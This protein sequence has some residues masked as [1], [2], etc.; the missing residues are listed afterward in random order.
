[1]FCVV[2]SCI[3]LIPLAFVQNGYFLVLF[4]FILMQHNLKKK[5]KQFF[6]SS[7]RPLFEGSVYKRAGQNKFIFLVLFSIL[8]PANSWR[9]FGSQM[10]GLAWRLNLY[11][12]YDEHDPVDN[13][14]VH[15]IVVCM[16]FW[17]YNFKTLECTIKENEST[18]MEKVLLSQ[19]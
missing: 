13:C 14:V 10:Y 19:A 6:I 4:Y 1:M 7:C 3:Y 17:L 11:K 16:R 18:R 12:Q 8:L 15:C 9:L 2:R 5:M